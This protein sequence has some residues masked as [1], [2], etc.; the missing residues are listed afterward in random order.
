ML[1]FLMQLNDNNNNNNDTNNNIFQTAPSC[2]SEQA[3]DF[4]DSI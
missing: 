1:Y 3:A 2:L 4:A